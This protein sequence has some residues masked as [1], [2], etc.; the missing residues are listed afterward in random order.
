MR[1]WICTIILF[2]YFITAMTVQ[3]ICADAESNAIGKA[4]YS[5]IDAYINNHLIPSYNINDC[6]AIIAEDLE[7]YGFD[8]HYDEQQRCLSITY[9]DQKEVTA[10]NTKEKHVIGSSAFSLYK[11]DI[12]VKINGK[13]INYYNRMDGEAAYNIGGK[14]MIFIDD[15]YEYGNV[16]WN[17]Y[18]RKIGFYYVPIW[19]IY[20]PITES[21]EQTEN[22]SS[23]HMELKKDKLGEIYAE[24]ENIECLHFFNMN[25]LGNPK[26][27]QYSWFRNGKVNFEFHILEKD[28][29]KTKSLMQTLYN[30]ITID[31]EGNAIPNR[32]SKANEHITIMINGEKF[33]ISA[34]EFRPDYHSISY[35]FEI[36]KVIKSINDIQ[37]ITIECK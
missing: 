8:V 1:K 4:V 6:T 22:I 12:A 10:N 16:I 7:N 23:F 36:D 31:S 21:K 18:E 32:I 27:E 24:G 17:E 26:I 14:T 19:S 28:F 13:I 15:L 2:C 25:W 5:D 29:I 11:S 37:N 9:N 35:Y 20:P 33:A 30:I 34:V 3:T